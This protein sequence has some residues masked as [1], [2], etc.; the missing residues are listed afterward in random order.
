MPFSYNPEAKDLYSV[1]TL[2]TLLQLLKLPDG[3]VK[4]LVEGSQRARVQKIYDSDSHF[5]ADLEPL[6]TDDEDN[7]EIEAMR[8]AIVQQFDQYVKLNKKVPPEI[9]ASLS[10]I[11]DPGRLADTIAAHLPIKI[12]QKQGILVAM[13]CPCCGAGA[14]SF[15]FIGDTL[16]EN[17]KELEAAMKTK[18]AE[19][20]EV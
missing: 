6:A 11:D 20:M 18:E 7:A 1:G 4:V 15:A 19:L 17:L 2:G 3:T 13:S 9:L 5:Y 16:P 8:R 14:L 10:G 12:E